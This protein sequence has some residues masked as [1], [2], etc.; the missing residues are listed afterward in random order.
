ME[1][2]IVFKPKENFR[3]FLQWVEKRMDI[4]WDRYCGSYDID[5]VKD[6]IL[7]TYKFCNVYRCLDRVSQ[8]L[9]K[10]I[11]NSDK[12]KTPEH[13]FW[14]IILFKH[15]NKIETW[16]FLEQKFEDVASADIDKVIDV[17]CEYQN[18]GAVIYSNAYMMT[19]S[20]FSESADL[21]KYGISRQTNSKVDAYLQ[22]Y[23]YW[24]FKQDYITRCLNTTSLEG[25][26]TE[27]HKIPTIGPFL[28]MQYATDLNYSKLFNFS[29][30]D[31]IIPGPGC[32]RGIQRTF[33]CSDKIPYE[34]I[35][36]WVH[37]NWDNLCKE[38][39]VDPILL[40]RKPSLMD[41]QNCFCETDKY[42]RQLGV[43]DDG[44]R[45]ERMKNY[46]KPSNKKIEYEFPYKWGLTL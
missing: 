6:P 42:I 14:A 45:G 30:N 11:V 36:K 25:L 3:Y 38:Y 29:E 10:N 9:I 40:E 46:F 13:L 18:Q 7:K 5:L 20:F 24:F 41:I 4:F 37:E 21:H 17:L 22:I 23:R 28:A 35:I 34:E 16:E 31:F 19:A 1:G 2:S 27:L 44:V 32:K 12:Y 33:S 8:Y 26:V 43:S 15:F 39:N